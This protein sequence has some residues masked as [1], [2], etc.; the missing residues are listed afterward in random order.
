M[1]GG[2]FDL[3]GRIACV[4]GAST[5]IGRAIAT[6]FAE[7]GAAVVGVARREAQLDDWRGAVEVKGGR[8]HACVADL[9]DLT[10][11][12]ETAERI[13]TAAGAP[14]RPTAIS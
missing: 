9:A 8:A 3:S 13:T 6:A 4:T 14:D 5:G 7:A 10:A 11:V 12:P 1:S 2:L